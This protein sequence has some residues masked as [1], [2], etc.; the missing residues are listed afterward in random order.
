MLLLE[1][2]QFC[3]CRNSCTSHQAVS[4]SLGVDYMPITACSG[5]SYSWQMS[6]IAWLFPSVLCS[7]RCLNAL[8]I[9]Y[10]ASFLLLMIK[11]CILSIHLRKCFHA[12]THFMPTHNPPNIHN[13]WSK[14][15]EQMGAVLRSIAVSKPTVHWR[16]KQPTQHIS[17]ESPIKEV[18]AG[19]ACKSSF[20]TALWH[21]V[22]QTATYS[23]K[24][25][26]LAL[27]L[28]IDWSVCC[29]PWNKCLAR[30][31]K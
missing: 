10:I 25:K 5:I 8:D 3:D 16:L 24:A 9:C 31:N 23:N 26:L 6:C 30:I 18:K 14:V 22:W 20:E 19:W 12:P 1:N 17:P 11:I 29:Q 2:D 27:R 13:L 21:T 15:D 28:L 7:T 4:H